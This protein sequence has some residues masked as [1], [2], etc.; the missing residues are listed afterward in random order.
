MQVNFSRHALKRMSERGVTYREVCNALQ[1]PDRHSIK[2]EACLAARQRKD[3]YWLIV[4]YAGSDT[5]KKV[6]TVIIISKI[7][8]FFPYEN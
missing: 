8:K 1:Y 5:I 6:I 3:G 7:H 4:I 2:H